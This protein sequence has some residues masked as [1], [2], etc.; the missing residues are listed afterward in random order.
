MQRL[1]ET[2]AG[3]GRVAMPGAEFND[4]QHVSRHDGGPVLA[5][6]CCS[7]Q[8]KAA[9]QCTCQALLVKWYGNAANIALAEESLQLFS[10]TLL[11][12]AVPRLWR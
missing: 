6:E 5:Y 8:R 4:D 10:C 7:V 1:L 11:S 12:I 3:T 2:E 9:K